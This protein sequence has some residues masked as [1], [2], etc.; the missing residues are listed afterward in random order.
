MVVE[1][2]LREH[3]A[4][5]TYPAL[6][7]VGFRHLK[8]VLK[9]V[10]GRTGRW[11]GGKNVIESTPYHVNIIKTKIMD[12]MTPRWCFLQLSRDL[13]SDFVLLLSERV[14]WII[15]TSRITKCPLKVHSSKT[16][17]G[18]GFH[19]WMQN[20]IPRRS[21]WQTQ[22]LCESVPSTSYRS[23]SEC[24]ETRVTGSA[25]PPF[26]HSRTGRTRGADPLPDGH[27]DTKTFVC[28]QS[29]APLEGSFRPSSPDSH[30]D[31]WSDWE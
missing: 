21:S 15:P 3:G 2:S 25:T 30:R 18:I 14:I 11:A 8:R 16:T 9:S 17:S 20:M 6:V 10:I 7:K 19:I 23:I 5:R 4:E 27:S 22:L 24:T 13:P 12:T 26:R 28:V 1:R 29:P 31:E